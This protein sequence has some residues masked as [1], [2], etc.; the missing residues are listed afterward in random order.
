M[1]VFRSANGSTRTA[2][3]S[4]TCSKSKRAISR[5]PVC[6]IRAGSPCT[7]T[8]SRCIKERIYLDKANPNLLHDETTVIDNALTRPWTVD[9]KYIRNADTLAE[10]PESVC[11]EVNNS[12]FI[13]KEYYFMS[14]DG[15]LMP[16]KKGQKPPDARYFDKVSN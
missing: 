14:A 6:T 3:A 13:G 10:W 5:A 15:Y 4:T 16:S 1:R 8:I 12:V 2:T 9:K 7:A 11:T